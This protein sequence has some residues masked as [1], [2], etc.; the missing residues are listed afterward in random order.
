MRSGREFH[1]VLIRAVP[2]LAAVP[3]LWTLA[4]C[5][6]PDRGKPGVQAP[7]GGVLV[8][9]AGATFPSLLYRRWFANYQDSHPKT[10][11]TY[12]SVG[13]GEGIRRFIGKNVK[14]EDKVDFGAS[15]AAMK[16][17]EIAQVTQGVLLLPVT[18]GSVV[19]AY[20]LPEFEGDLKLS[21][22]AYAGIFLGEVKNWNDPLI[23]ETNPDA[24]LPKLTIAVVVRSDSSGTTYAFTKHLDAIDEK[25]RGQHGPATL[26]TWPGL[27]MRAPGNEGVAGR[28]QHSIG[29]VGYLGYEFARRLGLRMALLENKQG[30]FVKPTEQS[31][32]AALAEAQLPENLRF[33]MPDPSGPDSY[34]IVTFSWILSYRSYGDAQK[35]KTIRDL[36]RWC[37]SDGQ[38]DAP[39]LNYLPL[40]PNVTAKA[41]SELSTITPAE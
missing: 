8:K 13:S 40:P 5:S 17:E 39:K 25:W 3:L 7:A 16:D 11:V 36:F 31:C 24:K 29:S 10:V 35:A 28:I 33:F 18:A 41:L 22:K 23:A 4:S 21:R 27:V 37:L 32:T 9:G 26:V 38:N 15:D 19:L 1:M 14:E 12:D 6:G 30:N 2:L 34:P 20:N